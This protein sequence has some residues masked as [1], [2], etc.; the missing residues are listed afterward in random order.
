MS[1]GVKAFDDGKKMWEGMKM[2]AEGF[3]VEP[4]QVGV[5]TK[6]VEGQATGCDGSSAGERWGGEG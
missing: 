1:E 6:S 2:V 5:G 3:P 4:S